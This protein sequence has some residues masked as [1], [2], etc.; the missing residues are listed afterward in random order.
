MSK[1]LYILGLLIG[2]L[3]GLS[4]LFL[5]S[6]QDICVYSEVGWFWIAVFYVGA[7]IF[8]YNLCK[9]VELRGKDE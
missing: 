8:G 6:C 9:L 3:V 7:I 1:R 2:V 4:P 5:G